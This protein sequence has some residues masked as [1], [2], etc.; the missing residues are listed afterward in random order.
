MFYSRAT[1][2]PPF[3]RPCLLFTV[4]GT[5]I[6]KEKQRETLIGGGTSST[7]YYA[8]QMWVLIICQESTEVYG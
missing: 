7:G 2:G 6:R 1:V 3:G 5:Y 8:K 4:Y